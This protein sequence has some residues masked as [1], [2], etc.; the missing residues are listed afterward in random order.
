[1]EK[2]ASIFQT[3]VWPV[4]P[5]EFSLKRV[6]QRTLNKLSR[7]GANRLKTTLAEL[8]SFAGWCEQHGD[9]VYHFARGIYNLYPITRTFSRLQSSGAPIA[10]TNIGS[11]WNLAAHCWYWL[12]SHNSQKDSKRKVSIAQCHHINPQKVGYITRTYK[13]SF[14]HQSA[15]GEPTI[16]HK[17]SYRS[18]PGTEDSWRVVQLFLPFARLCHFLKPNPWG[19]GRRSEPATPPIEQG[20]GQWW[21]K[22]HW[23]PVKGV[24][25][26][27]V[28][29]SC[30]QRNKQT[31]SVAHCWTITSIQ[32]MILVLR[33]KYGTFLQQEAL[34]C[35]DVVRASGY[36]K[37][38]K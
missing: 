38:N 31:E 8:Q 29:F 6:L 30:K 3:L 17:K 2:R 32:S 14:A 20:W 1:M 18:R 16:E 15:N 37:I 35:D 13:D 9:W 22:I 4:W 19:S 23:K 24:F 21:R 7:T 11:E 12:G 36:K 10:P 33:I 28:V 25:F 34:P 27:L 5:R 26:F